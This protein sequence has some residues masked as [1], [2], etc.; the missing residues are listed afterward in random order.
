MTLPARKRCP[1]GTLVPPQ[2]VPRG[3]RRSN[4]VYLRCPVCRLTTPGRKPENLTAAWNDTVDRE[5]ARMREA[6]EVHR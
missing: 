6:K 1:C 4:L 5:V 2:P 3:S